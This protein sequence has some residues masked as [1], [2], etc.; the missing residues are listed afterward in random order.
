ML[1]PGFKQE[2]CNYAG[3]DKSIAP[4]PGKSPKLCRTSQVC[5]FDASKAFEFVKHLM[6]IFKG[7]PLYGHGRQMFLQLE[8]NSSN[9]RCPYPGRLNMLAWHVSQQA[10]CL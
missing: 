3:A 5:I 10:Q 7:F 2:I 4:M 8:I 9:F 1:F 6:N